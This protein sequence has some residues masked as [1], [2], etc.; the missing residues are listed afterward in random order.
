[1]KIKDADTVQ[2][3]KDYMANGRFSR[4]QEVTGYASFS[5]VGNFDLNIPRIVNSY[6]HDLLVTLPEAFDLAV[7]DRIY[8]YI[9][10]WDGL[11]TDYMSEALH[12]LF[13][14]DSDYVGI[15][16]TR[17]K[18]GDNIE[19]RD[20][21]A[22][23]KTISGFIKLLFPTGQPTDEEFDEIVEYAIEG[24]R[25]VKEQLNKRKPDEEYAN[26]NMSYINRNGEKVVVWKC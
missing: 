15:V 18:K 17:L 20:N 22:L 2:I 11:I 25:R 21:R 1:M 5:F 3:M 7:I 10:G 9:P 8:N 24:R 12:Y 4:G 16:N 19:G 23:Q 14:H 13:V 26:I 6:D